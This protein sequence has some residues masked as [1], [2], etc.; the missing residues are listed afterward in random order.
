[1]PRTPG[2]VAKN[3]LGCPS[4]NSP[5]IAM[6]T[7]STSLPPVVLGLVRSVQVG[8]VQAN[9]TTG[10]SDPL[11]RPWRSAFHKMPLAGPV[12]VGPLGLAGDEQSDRRH[13]GGPDKAVL[14]Y[15]ADHYPMW[16]DEYGLAESG[17]GGFGENLSVA[18]FS[19]TDVCIGDRLAI[20]RTLVLEVSQPR[21]PC[22]N[23]NRRWGRKGVTE[24]VA[25]NGR[26][27]WYL[28]V[29]EAGALRAGDAVELAE[30]P[31][32]GL[33]VSLANDAMYQRTRDPA[34]LE[35]L[36]ACPQMPEA[37]KR[38]L[39]ARLEEIAP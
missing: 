37:F 39:R 38:G 3:M 6:S 19:E 20:G 10:A 23:I 14:M 16:Q 22:S 31:H 4:V 8:R 18:G 30:R 27:G 24:A 35:R 17:P 7:S 34:V 12:H 36:L 2:Q 9:G 15:A 11:N 25:E 32:P 33:T 13:H 5:S 28:R 26:G 1:M 21:Q 29:I